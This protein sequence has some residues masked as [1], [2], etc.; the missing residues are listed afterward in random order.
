MWVQNWKQ[1]GFLPVI[2]QQNEVLQKKNLN[3]RRKIN[4][5]Q[6]ISFSIGCFS[7]V[8]PHEWFSVI[9]HL[10]QERKAETFEYSDW[11]IVTI[12]HPEQK[13]RVR[14]GLAFLD[15]QL[16]GENW[17]QPL[18]HFW[19]LGSIS[20]PSF[21]REKRSNKNKFGFEPTNIKVFVKN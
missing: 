19:N 7:T 8:F 18:V 15:Q 4:K 1:N 10:E 17:S 2:R 11:S 14:T 6:E 13:M 12:F 9:P 21:G 16:V 3:H 5:Q 20:N